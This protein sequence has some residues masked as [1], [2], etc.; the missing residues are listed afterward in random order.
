VGEW[1]ELR[2]DRLRPEPVACALCGRP[3]FARVWS[4]ERGEFC[5]GEC[6]RLYVEYWLPRQGAEA[7][8]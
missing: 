6:E 4:S 5:D 2:L 8:R 7:E 3:L 1:R